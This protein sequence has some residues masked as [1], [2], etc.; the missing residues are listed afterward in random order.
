MITRQEI[1]HYFQINGYQ[2][3]EYVGQNTIQISKAEKTL[4]LPLK[5]NY[6]QLYIYFIFQLNA[7]FFDVPFSW[8]IECYKMLLHIEL[9]KL[10]TKKIK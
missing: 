1:Q 6:C 7:S 5:K 10:Q 8:K 3:I 9:N 2:Y 4:I